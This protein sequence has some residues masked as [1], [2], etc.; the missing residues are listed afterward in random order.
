MIKVKQLLLFKDAVLWKWA[1]PTVYVPSDY[2]SLINK[3]KVLTALPDQL[4]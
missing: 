1:S 4:L 3:I 2:K